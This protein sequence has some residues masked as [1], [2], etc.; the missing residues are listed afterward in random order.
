MRECCSNKRE[1]EMGG[2]EE[3]A[4]IPG[5]PDDIALDCLARVPHRFHSSL[6]PVCRRWR[7]L[8]TAPFFYEH[9]DRIGSA[10]DLIFL[11]QALVPV[12]NG[13]QETA[14]EVKE[15]GK[16]MAAA[17]T[18]CRPPVYGL[19]LYNA[20]LGEWRRLAVAEPV[21]MFAQCAATGGKV[22]LVGG[23]D[24]VTLDPVEEV[25]VLDLV[26]GR[27]RRGASMVAARSFFACAAAGGR[28]FVAGGHDGQKN[29]LRS[30]EAYD[31]ATDQWAALPE[32]AE[33]RDECQGAAAAAAGGKFWAV[34]GYGTES[35][36][37]FDAAAE[38]YDAEAGEWRREEG[39][40]EVG[41]AGGG[42]GGAACFAAAGELWCVDV[43]RGVRGYDGMGRGWRAV[44]G[45][46]E[47]L[48][49]SPCAAAMGGAAAG[50]RVFVMGAEGEGAQGGRHGGWVFEMG[51]KK[52]TR[53]E[54][55]TGFTGFVYSAAAVRL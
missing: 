41:D 19:S 4:L 35:Q 23:W 18:K 5:L 36:G 28:V 22:V 21:P 10:E 38:W 27:W 11:V 42:F 14:G 13:H 54:T 20:T 31:V 33:E 9:R 45:V 46:P 34:S 15:Q 25:R 3:K 29:A 48:R 30:A 6:R 8:V 1:R 50:E 40:W 53:V 2:E 49:S 39:V 37:R 55:P 44:A 51:S 26:T 43:R 24:P 7:D 52:W 32:M 47:M 17:A 16:E 12:G